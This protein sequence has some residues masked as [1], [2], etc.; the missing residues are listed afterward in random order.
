MALLAALLVFVHL[1]AGRTHRALRQRVAAYLGLD[2][3]ADTPGQRTYD[4]RRLR[5]KGLLWRAPRSHRYRVTPYGYRVALLFTKL[6]A[7]VFRTTFAAFEAGE[8]V[9]RPLAEALA[10]VD[11]QLSLILD[12][13][14]LERAA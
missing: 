10:E 13:A 1:P 5:L 3:A 8:P 12:E 6:D 9:P 14:K 2:L 11:R 4:L 7:R